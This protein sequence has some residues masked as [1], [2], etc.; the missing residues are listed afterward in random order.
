MAQ[1]NRRESLLFP[2]GREESK[3]GQPFI[4]DIAAGEREKRETWRA[5]R[6]EFE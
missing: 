2:E 6:V 4:I 1:G 5:V 3:R